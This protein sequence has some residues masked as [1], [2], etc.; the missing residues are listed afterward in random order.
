[1]EYDLDGM[2]ALA[3]SLSGA[4]GFDYSIFNNAGLGALNGM[5]NPE[6]SAYD[7]VSGALSQL[8]SSVFGGGMPAGDGAM[9]AA[10]DLGGSGTV[11]IPTGVT[12]T[13]DKVGSGAGKLFSQFSGMLNNKNGEL[14]LTK[15][16]K[17]SAGLASAINGIT[18]GKRQSKAAEEAKAL[19]AQLQQRQGS[20]NPQQQQWANSYFNSPRQARTLQVGQSTPSSMVAGRGYARGGSV[21]DMLPPNV[22]NALMYQNPE[23]GERFA[24]GGDVEPQGALGLLYGEGG[25]QDDKIEARLSP[26]EYV[27]DADT[28]SALGDGSNEAGAAILDEWRQ[29][30]RSHKRSAP[31][32]EIPPPAHDPNEYLPGAE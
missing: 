1:M 22:V 30:I 9:T 2:D 11:Q 31:E 24:E 5:P 14:D 25:G 10:S 16:L 17:M 32:T 7:Q 29:N 20:F 12:D 26:G 21:L 4:D 3:S 28:V 18:S 15:V 23:H 6:P 27:F 13:L 8:G 19:Q